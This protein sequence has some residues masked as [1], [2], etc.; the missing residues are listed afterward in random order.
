MR[1]T[2]IALAA[3]AVALAACPPPVA[4]PTTPE[5]A[6]P[7]PDRV[8]QGPTAHL[9]PP[10]GEPKVD[11]PPARPPEPARPPPTITVKRVD[12]P[13]DVPGTP[14][15]AGEWRV[16]LIDVGTGLAIL[17]QGHD[18]NLLYDAGTN[19]AGEK[20]LRVLAYL[21]ATVGPS[22]DSVCVAKGS[23]APGVRARLDHV[24]LSHPHADHASAMDEVVHCYDVGTFWDSGAINDTKFYGDL[25]RAIS[26]STNLAYRT[27]AVPPPDRTIRIKGSP[28]AMPAAVAWST[29]SEGD[30]VELGA[31]ARFT[32]LHAEAK[33]KDMNANSVVIAV[34]LGGARLLLTGDAESGP[35]K[36]P[37]A[38]LGDV[39][40]HLVT[41]FREAI[42]VDILQ[43]GHHGSKT[44]SRAAFL[45]A[46]SPRYALV[47][48]G[49][50]KYSGTTLPDAE[51]ITA[52]AAAGAEVLRTDARDKDCPASTRRIGGDKGSGG[53][54][55]YILTITR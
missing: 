35:R 7:G 33:Q 16:H 27:A 49:P 50:K 9:P 22:G 19:D 10:A 47:S 15:A 45:A 5:P 18:F 8:P 36:D 3:L 44:S 29:F 20:P 12:A 21:A 38:P 52:L 46:V 43:V 42:D 48:V 17:I 34:E 13:G 11:E 14:P 2:R 31:D 30:V 54:D 51:V 23:P 1:G 39:E 4:A 25:L 41:T 6:P 26:R 32:V 37:S 40:E 28:I 24:V 55:S 53:C